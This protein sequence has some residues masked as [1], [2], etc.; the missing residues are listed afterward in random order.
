MV[1]MGLC[2]T[3]QGLPHSEHLALSICSKIQGQEEDEV[4]KV[5]GT[6]FIQ[7]F[8]LGLHC[9]TQRVSASVNSVL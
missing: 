6:T 1:E 2:S 7:T 5:Q 4:S 9:A 3:M 8:L